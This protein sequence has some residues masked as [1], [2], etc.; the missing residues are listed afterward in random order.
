MKITQNNNSIMKSLITLF[1]SVF[2]FSLHLSSLAYINSSFLESLGLSNSIISI[3]FASSSVL[4]IAGIF[5]VPHIEKKYSPRTLMVI[6]LASI[7]LSLLGIIAGKSIWVILPII[8]LFFVLRSL[9][10]FGFDVL[11]EHF[12]DPQ[13]VGRI[14]GGLIVISSIAWGI[15]P[16]IA[17][18]IIKKS[19]F[20]LVYTMGIFLVL[21]PLII[22][23]FSF[24]KE[25]FE[26]PKTHP[27][28]KVLISIIRNKDLS[29]SFSLAFALNVFYAL[30]VVYI[31]MHLSLVIGFDWVEIGFLI[32][33]AQLPF[34][35]LGYPIGKIAD[36]LI[37][38]KEIM[39]TGISIGIMSLIGMIFLKEAS[40]LAWGIL[41]FISRVGMSLLE[42]GS[43]SYFFKKVESNEVEKISVQRNAVPLAYLFMSLCGVITGIFTE[44]LIPLFILGII[45]FII[46]LYP[47]ITLKDTR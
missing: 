7:I 21:V 13:F 19:G 37:G 47:A 28:K 39:I 36:V 22:F 6:A 44:S 46:S 17:G 29:R 20:T 14:R 18:Q 4:I 12:S 16:I 33:T 32:L 30:A 34:I 10:V 26:K 2:F 11:F 40:F 25:K 8:I 5:L 23:L 45:T 38:E 31:P 15:G 41:F 24:K 3:I 1:V 42:T 9:V 43:D 35:I 27:L